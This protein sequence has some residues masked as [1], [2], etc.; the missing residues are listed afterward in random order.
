VNWRL[1]PEVE[2]LP[3]FPQ[4]YLLKHESRSI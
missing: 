3:A 2:H 1:L 4:H